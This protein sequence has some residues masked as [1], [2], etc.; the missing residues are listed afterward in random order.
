VIWNISVLLLGVAPDVKDT[1]ALARCVPTVRCEQ[2][3]LNV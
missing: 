3:V 1:A 2:L